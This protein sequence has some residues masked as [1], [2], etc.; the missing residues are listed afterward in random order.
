MLRNQAPEFQHCS[1]TR[2]MKSVWVN[3]ESSPRDD[4]VVPE[5][6]VRDLAELRE[7]FQ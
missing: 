6:E 1:W 7:A 2:V 3:R 4:T 5:L